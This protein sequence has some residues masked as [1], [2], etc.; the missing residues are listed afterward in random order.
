MKATD[1]TKKQYVIVADSIDIMRE[2]LQF[3]LYLIHADEI[4][5]PSKCVK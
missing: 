5:I 1:K 2:E 3:H 4:L